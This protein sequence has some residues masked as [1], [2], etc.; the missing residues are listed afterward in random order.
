MVSY[1]VAASLAAVTALYLFC[2]N[3][4][5]DFGTDNAFK[6]NS[7][8]IG[9]VNRGN[10]CFINSVLQAL[11][12]LN[13][14]RAHLDRKTQIGQSTKSDSLIVNQEDSKDEA[15]TSYPE[16]RQQSVRECTTDDVIGALQILLDELNTRSYYKKCISARPLVATLERSLGQRINKSQQDA[17]EFLQ[18][19]I[20]Q[21]APN[22]GSGIR[23][24]REPGG[25]MIAK[26]EDNSHPFMGRTQARIECRRCNY[27][28]KATPCPFVMLNL[29]VPQQ[30]TASLNDCLDL[31]FKLEILEEYL[32]PSCHKLDA[33]ANLQQQMKKATA[34][35][36]HIRCKATIKKLEDAVTAHPES[37]LESLRIP[38]TTAAPRTKINRTLRIISFPAILTLHL[39]RS[40]FSQ[41]G[42]SVKNTAMVTFEEYLTLGGLLDRRRYK[43][44]AM[45]AHKGSHNSGHY[46]AFRRQSS[47]SYNRTSDD[48][49]IPKWDRYSTAA[50]PTVSER[51]FHQP[52]EAFAIEGRARKHSSRGRKNKI[53]DLWWRISDE[54]VR[55]C[56]TLDVQAM[57]KDVYLLFYE[58][59][60]GG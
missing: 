21:L 15:L 25:R 1:A 30:A 40:V 41:Y 43:L 6:R 50:P 28:S 14:L 57:L 49:K 26:P 10:D 12:G 52:T 31:H 44:Q 20:E 9:L 34:K 54:T 24:R 3:P 4:S 37:T 55:E 53:A 7:I 17:Q 60:G 32:C 48:G 27:S 19:L 5:L 51:D 23:E 58:L 46:E 59:E 16:T 42:A 35:E 38:T 2:P 8:A 39:S 45:I 13:G 22:D 47:E 18:V 29:V 33:L 56:T 11:A 36:Q